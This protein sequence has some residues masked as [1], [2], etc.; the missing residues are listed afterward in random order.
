MC[1][2]W[3]GAVSLL[4]DAHQPEPGEALDPVGQYAALWDSLNADRAPW[5]SNPWVWVVTFK[6]SETP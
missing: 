2:A 1:G 3:A 6:R 5:K 4:E